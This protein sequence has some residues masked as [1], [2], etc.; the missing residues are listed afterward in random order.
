M[1]CVPVGNVTADTEL[2][3]EY[4]VKKSKTSSQKKPSDATK[5]TKM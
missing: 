3:Y 5:G 4:G 1:L 2:S